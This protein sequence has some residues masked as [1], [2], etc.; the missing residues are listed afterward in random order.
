MVNFLVKR[1]IAVTMTFLALM[2]LG[3]VSMTRLPVSLMPDIDIPEI[4]VQI[5]GKNTPVRQ[6]ENGVVRPIRR[7]LLQVPHL[8]DI[9]SETRDENAL[10]RM[11]F[12]Y[13]TN[14]DLAF[15]DVNEKIDRSMNYLPKNIPRPRVIKASASD[16]P[17]FYLN[18]TAKESYLPGQ[19]KDHGGVSDRFTEL[20]RFAGQVIKKRLEQLPEVAMAD[21]SG[22]VE[23][24]ITIIP[25]EQKLNSI[26]L[27]NSDVERAIRANNLQLGNIVVKD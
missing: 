27:T 13:G 7:Q 17:V 11:K 5:E 12:E 6:L 9:Q 22:T 4:T 1:P 10:I 16:I 21:I 24:Q 8:S 2:I 26:N 23:S 14:V 19:S 20:S 15:I 25:D 3:L 18:I